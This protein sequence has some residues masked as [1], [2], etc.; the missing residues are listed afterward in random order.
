M[1]RKKKNEYAEALKY[2]MKLKNDL[3]TE[4]EWLESKHDYLELT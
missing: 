2:Q 3:K 1:N 4:K